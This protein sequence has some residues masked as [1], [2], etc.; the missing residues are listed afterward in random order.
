MNT[1]NPKNIGILGGTFDPI[2]LGHTE[3]A[4]VAANY[5]SLDKILFIPANIPYHKESPDVSAK[6]RAEMVTLACKEQASFYCDQRELERSGNTYTVDTLKSLRLSYPNQD[7][8][9]IIGI[10]SLLTFTQWHQYQEILS[11][12]HLVV[13]SRPNYPLKNLNKDTEKLLEKHHISDLAALKTQHSGGIIFVPNTMKSLQ[14][15]QQQLLPSDYEKKI[16][17]DISSTDIR[18]R[19]AK[20]QNCQHLLASTVLDFINKNALYR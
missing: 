8:F 17:L 6:Q 7:L 16:N 2:H 3:P 15:S 9:F 12:C 13:N 14:A 1:A 19:I 10:D 20:K 11:L 4:K 18:S 5:L